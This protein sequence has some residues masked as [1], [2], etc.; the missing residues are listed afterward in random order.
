MK[1]ILLILIFSFINLFGV[2][3]D[4][5]L[6]QEE[7]QEKIEK[8][9][10]FEKKKFFTKTILSNPK[11]MLKD[12]IDKIFINSDITFIAPGNISFDAYVE[13]NGKI[14]YNNKKKEIYLQNLEIETLVM[15]QIP[16]KFQN[17]LKVTLEKI[18]PIILNRYP[19]YTIKSNDFKKAITAML[20]KNIKV[21][22]NFM[23]ITL[24]V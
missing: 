23:I 15:D 22:N 13:L 21:E 19:I 24:G 10:P 9:F 1:K 7:L 3:Y 4:I 6:S 16:L 18:L 8:K 11:V 17:T 20:L 14:F 12:G 5:K 2:E